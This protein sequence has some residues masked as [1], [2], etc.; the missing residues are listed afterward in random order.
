MYQE[1]WQML[2]CDQT[3]ARWN[4]RH[5]ADVGEQYLFAEEHPHDAKAAGTDMSLSTTKA[6]T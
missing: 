3:V 5:E 6:V 2:V 1:K 4:D